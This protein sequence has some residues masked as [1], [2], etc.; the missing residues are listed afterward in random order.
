M[1]VWYAALDI[2]PSSWT[3]ARQ[4]ATPGAI[5]V[6]TATCSGPHV[7]PRTS[8]GDQPAHQ[9]CGGG[10]THA[11]ERGGP[12]GSADIDAVPRDDRLGQA[13][14]LLEF[15]LLVGVQIVAH[16]RRNDDLD[17]DQSLG[18][19]PRDQPPGSRPGYAEPAGDLG[20]GEAVEVIERRR[21]QGQPQVFGAG[22]AV[23]GECTSL[24]VDCPGDLAVRR[25]YGHGFPPQ[26]PIDP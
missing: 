18:L 7:N 5:A 11:G 9:Q 1:P 23:F 4:L 25:R 26:L 16:V 13:E 14:A 2:A 19:G 20:L 22:A 3:T 6:A 15:A 17:A 10:A 8:L 21:A 12:S 24:G